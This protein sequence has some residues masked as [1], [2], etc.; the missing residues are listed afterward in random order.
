M[1]LIQKLTIPNELAVE[2]IFLIVEITREGYPAR[3]R[4]EKISIHSQP[5]KDLFEFIDKFKAAN[6]GID[7][8][9]WDLYHSPSAK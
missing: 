7:I 6:L 9:K 5:L 3:G 2:A 4:V 8:Y 1:P